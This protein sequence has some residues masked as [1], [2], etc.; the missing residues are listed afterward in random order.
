MA[1]GQE[2]GLADHA[3]VLGQGQSDCTHRVRSS[4]AL[5]WRSDLLNSACVSLGKYK[6][7]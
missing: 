7:T 4:S 5:V 1:L 6:E 2:A 3:S